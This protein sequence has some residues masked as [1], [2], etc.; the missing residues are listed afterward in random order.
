MSELPLLYRLKLKTHILPSSSVDAMLYKEAVIELESL[1]KQRDTAL[2][3]LQ[4]IWDHY[5]KVCNNYEL[6]THDAC[7]SSYGAWAAADEC[8]AGDSSLSN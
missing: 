4:V 2:G 7:Q 8:L 1:Q 6:C 3:A 5:G